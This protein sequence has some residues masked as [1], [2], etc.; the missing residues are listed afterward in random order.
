MFGVL[1]VE[2]A[3]DYRAWTERTTQALKF[4]PGQTR[5]SW[6]LFLNDAESFYDEPI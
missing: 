4:K 3:Q 5:A 6:N 1:E 2:L